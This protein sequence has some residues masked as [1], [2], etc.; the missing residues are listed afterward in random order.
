LPEIGGSGQ[1][2]LLSSRVLIVGVGGLGSPAALYLAAGGIGTIGIADGDRV[3]LTNLPRQII[4]N[5][6]EVNTEKVKSA[7]ATLEALN[8]DVTIQTYPEPMGAENILPII[9]TYEFVID[10][11]DNGPAKFLI[12][13][14]CY[15]ERIAFSHAG[16]LQFYGQL[17]TVLP[18]ESACYRCIFPTPAP[19][20]LVPSCSQSGV[21][22]VVPGVIGLLQA[23]EAIK[24]LLGIGDLLTD[25]LLQYDA[26]EMDFQKVRLKRNPRCPLCGVNPKITEL[27]DEE[28]VGRDA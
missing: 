1:E 11:T 6:R 7:K 28:Q 26:L 19:R 24:F 22:G 17:M 15:F 18:G 12:N 10:G 16:L 9:R 21:L 25:T 20:D 8:P 27:K 3:D 23:T 14:A 2:K 13:D 4:Y 5:T